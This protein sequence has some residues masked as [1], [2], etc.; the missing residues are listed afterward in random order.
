MSKSSVG[1]NPTLSAK[2]VKELFGKR[3]AKKAAALLLMLA[4]L[5]VPHSPV[6]AEAGMR[7]QIAAS[8]SGIPVG[9]SVTVT[10][11][12]TRLGQPVRGQELWAYVD[13]RQWGAQGVTNSQGRT[14]FIL[15][16]PQV[17]TARIQVAPPPAG[18]RWPSKTFGQTADFTVG[19]P[20]PPSSARS[21]PV[22]ITVKARRFSPTVDP[23]HLIGV[24]CYPWFTRYNAH[25]NGGRGAEGV[26]L[27]GS[28]AS[29]NPDVIR[30]Q[31]LWMDEIGVNFLQ[32]DWSNNL[33]SASHWADHVPGVSEM[34]ASTTVLL[35]TLAQ[36][37]R[38][39]LPTPQVQL[40]LGMAPPFSMT[41]LNEEMAWVHGSYVTNPKYAGLFVMY[42]GKPLVTVL[43][44]LDDA[45]L[46]KQGTADTT[47]FTLRWEWVSVA[48]RP[49]WWSWSD[50]YLAP[51]TAYFQG[52]AEAITVD[53]AFSTGKGW[54][55]PAS[56][57]KRGG[58]TW[59]QEFGTACA[60][61]PR[62]LVLHQ[63]NEWGEQYDTER[64]DEFEP[65]ALASL[66]RGGTGVDGGAG[67]GWGFFYLN[68]ARALVQVYHGGAPES[69]ILTAANPLQNS[70]VS[71]PSVTVAW[72]AIGKPVANYGVLLDGVV[73]APE[74]R[75]NSYTL[76]LSG[77]PR[78]RH[79]VT[80][81]ANG[82]LTRFPLS[83][84]TDDEPTARPRPC[85]VSVSFI[86]GDPVAP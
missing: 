84:T 77:V 35:D 36:M 71:G 16:L 61:R 43:S 29:A 54:T 78:G 24:Q 75:G 59:V 67:P 57:G 52:A 1:S 13:G 14:S 82:A 79:V 45:A 53:A 81:R 33:T 8:P 63:F 47:Q 56:V 40:L 22:S 31:M 85:A 55:D 66:G 83:L 10:A 34:V 19:T 32:L 42:R 3:M 12:A 39:G 30:Q 58:A 46:A 48:D 86:T 23:A 6:R 18:F 2:T 17:G 15:P 62:F 49:G 28:Y 65:A 11:L 76:S 9:K 72:R 20:L 73:R 41:A 38:E 25:I 51:T 50:Q 64:S 80:V 4:W 26:P 68:L 7:L 44:V 70:R 21:N 5:C 69:T 27:L 37:R 60:T 74:V